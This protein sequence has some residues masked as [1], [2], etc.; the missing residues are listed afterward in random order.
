MASGTTTYND[1]P[2]AV[3]E[4]YQRVTLD[5]AK[6]D[7]V[8]M[9][10]AEESQIAKNSGDQW[11]ARRYDPYPVAIAPMTDGVIKA[12]R[13]PT[14]Q[15]IKLELDYYGDHTEITKRVQYTNI[16]NAMLNISQ[17][18]GTQAGETTDTLMRNV[19]YSGASYINASNGLN[20]GTPTEATYKDFQTVVK[21]LRLNSAQKIAKSIQ[22]GTGF[23][24]SPI[25]M[26]YVAFFHSD[27]R[28]DIRKIDT[29]TPV[30]QYGRE[31]QVYNGEFGSIDD[32]R[33]IETNNG[34]LSSGTYSI[35]IAG[36]KSYGGVHLSGETLNIYRKGFGSAGT[37]DPYN[38]FA[39]LAWD[40]M[41]GGIV[42]NDAWMSALR[43][44]HS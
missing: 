2:P 30:H 1:L 17:L 11:L 40:T 32:I 6:K 33:L 4:A 15:D 43:V 3:R 12:A 37:A 34:Y 23:N 9:Q 27:L 21:L 44:T 25:G 35:F 20:G 39:T 5:Y 41:W 7:Q 36:D 22:A 16:E 28:D 31:G 19:L 26:S 10:F 24:T 18:H 13:K 8:Y 29:F 14:Y 38:M 42:Q